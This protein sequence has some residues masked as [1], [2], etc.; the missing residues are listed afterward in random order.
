[1]AKRGACTQIDPD[2][3]VYEATVK[4]S[5]FYAVAAM[6]RSNGSIRAECT[7][8]TFQNYGRYC[9][10]IAAVLLNAHDIRRGKSLSVRSYA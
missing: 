7:C 10:H 1:R 9:K 2:E 6:I 5:S 4:G 8:S 3:G